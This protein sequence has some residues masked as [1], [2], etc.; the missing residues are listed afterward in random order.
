MS[1]IYSIINKSNGKIY[2]G[3]TSRPFDE[4]KSEHFNRLNRQVHS[5]P[6][7]QSAWNKY[8]ED[9]FEFNILENCPKEDLGENEDWWI[10]YFDSTN[11]SKGYNLQ[12]GGVSDYT[13][14]DETR[15]KQSEALKGYKHSEEFCKKISDARKGM[16]FS[17]THKRNMSKSKCKSLNNSGFYRVHKDKDSR[18][19]QGF[20]YVY[21]WV[22]NGKNKKITSVSL[23][24]LKE[25]VLSQ[26]LVWCRIEEIG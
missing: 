13:V 23:D 8:G 4:R 20:R 26:G 6:H 21:K 2:V 18:Y 15:K 9:A 7:L 19:A 1:G 11:Q 16:V 25:K 17:E 22:E 10:T 3:Q 12:S 14:S 24:K 5:N